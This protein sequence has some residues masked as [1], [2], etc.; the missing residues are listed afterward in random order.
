MQ[1]FSR[2]RKGQNL[3][4]EEILFIALAILIITGVS[5]TFNSINNRVSGDIEEQSAM[6]ISN[7]IIS[8]I[9]K[10][11]YSNATSGY[12][13]LEIPE[14]ISQERYLIS[15]F[16]PPQN[17]FMIKMGNSRKIVDVSVNVQGIV[18]SSGKIL[19]VE[20]D[21]DSIFLRGGEY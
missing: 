15:G 1:Y 3:V 11:V 14:T 20:Y 5:S 12:V 16:N 19:K 10:L 13:V 6:Q 4:L 9:D 21:G 17:K 18:S 7:F 8:A 2:K